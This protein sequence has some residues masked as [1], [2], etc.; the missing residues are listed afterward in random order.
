MTRARRRQ[1]GDTE[2]EAYEIRLL[3]KD[4]SILYALISN[5]VIEYEG[6]PATLMTIADLTDTK[7][8]RELEQANRELKKLVDRLEHISEERKQVLL[9]V[10]HDLRTPLTS[11][12]GF[13]DL[14]SNDA[15]ISSSAREYLQIINDEALRLN[16]LVNDILDISRDEAGKLEWHMEPQDL[17]QIVQSSISSVS[18]MA[19]EKGLNI[20]VNVPDNLPK[21]YGD[22]DRLQ[23]VMMNLL[24]NAIKSTF[25]GK[26]SVG[27]EKRE[28]D[29]LIW[30]ADSGIGIRDEDRPK[31]FKPFGRTTDRYDGAGL[32][33]S[34][35]K[36]IVDHHGGDIWFESEFGKGTTFYFTVGLA[37]NKS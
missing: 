5:A 21:V 10:S 32:G 35:C 4:G 23:Q 12:V 37:E 7:T 28:Q 25:E 31:L 6:R 13:S 17:S 18:V 14:L 1:A 15:N 8:R 3:K 11:I 29:M 24:S 2:P 19:E 30:V 20:E 36:M 33:L 16:R 34:I 26:V 22:K 9:Q 27:I